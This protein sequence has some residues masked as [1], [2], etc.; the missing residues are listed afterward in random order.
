MSRDALRFFVT[1]SRAGIEERESRL[2]TSP[3]GEPSRQNP[4]RKGGKSNVRLRPIADIREFVEAVR[5]TWGV[6]PLKRALWKMTVTIMALALTS[7]GR[8]NG[9]SSD[10]FGK[11]FEDSFAQKFLASCSRSLS[12]VGVPQMEVH[13]ACGC[14]LKKTQDRY[15]GTQKANLSDEQ[16]SAVT[17]ECAAEWENRGATNH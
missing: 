13:F 4:N 8:A 15:P 1:V 7:C 16:R 14:M 11:A 9:Q 17:R 10:A 5:A 3:C 6:R 12:N 2:A